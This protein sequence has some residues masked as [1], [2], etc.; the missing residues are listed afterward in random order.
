LTVAIGDKITITASGT[1]TFA[2]AE[3]ASPDG[4]PGGHLTVGG[5]S[6]LVPGAP[7]HTLVGRIG[8]SGSLLDISGFLV[9]SSFS[10]TATQSGTL[11]LG[12]NDGF[13]NGDRG[14]MNSGG[15]GD[16]SGS[17]TAT[18]TIS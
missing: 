2:G 6:L 3:A 8:S 12:F 10:Q 18:V 13:V 4:H 11:Y 7:S 16:N 14:S 15:V 5:R 17:F 9:G 1:I